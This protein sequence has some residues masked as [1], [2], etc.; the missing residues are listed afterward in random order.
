MDVEDLFTHPNGPAYERVERRE[1][2][3]LAYVA[4]K[5]RYC[6]ESAH[7]APRDRA[8]AE[9]HLDHA[10]RYGLVAYLALQN[11]LAL[12]NDHD[13]GDRLLALDRQAFSQWLDRLEEEGSVT[14]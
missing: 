1:G 13:L 4:E 12:A 11:L 10:F 14:G 8:D 6:L 3:P 9:R 7:S 2:P 5:L